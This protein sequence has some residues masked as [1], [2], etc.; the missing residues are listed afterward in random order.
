MLNSKL[1][2]VFFTSLLFLGILSNA[3]PVGYY[4]GT[5]GKNG[6]EL[7]T[8]LNEIISHHV[9]FGYTYTKYIINY[10]DADP[11]NP[12]N[13]ILFY[14]Q[15]SRDANDYGT[16]GDYINREHVWAKSHGNFTDKRPMYTDAHNLRPADASV[17]ED[18]GNKD[19]DN[20]QPGGNQNP[21][22]LYCYYTDSTWEPG[23]LT[24]GQVARILFY[25]A[26]RYE[27]N[28]GEMDL[29]LVRHNHT[30]PLPE[31]G[32]LDALLKWNKEY[33]PS[34]FERRRN[35][36][37][38]RAQ[39][40]RNPFVDHPEFADFI[41][42]NKT[43]DDIRFSN[44]SK[45]PEN[46]TPGDQISISLDITGSKTI[47]KVS[48]NWGKTYDSS[49]NQV[50]MQASGNN[51]TADIQPTDVI[52]GDMLYL[53]VKAETADSTY[54]WRASY[55]YPEKVD[56]ASITPIPDVQGTG[57]ASPIQNQEVT[58]A[59]RLTAN[60]DYSFYMQTSDG[61]RSGINVYNT[62]F[63]G[64]P[65]DSIIVRGTVDEY[66][67][68]TEITDVSYIHNYRSNKEV[69]PKVITTADFNEAHEGML[70]T[71]QN[72]S[73]QNGGQTIPEG[74]TSLTLADDSG[75]GTVFISST[76][77]LIGE[78]LLSGNVSVTGILGQY[79][80]TYQLMPRNINDIKIYTDNYEPRK[81]TSEINLYPNPVIDV[82]SINSQNS[83]AR[84]SFYNLTGQLVL[85]LKP[86]SNQVN[87][88]ALHPGIYLLR[89]NFS[90]GTTIQEK[91]LKANSK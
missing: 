38:Y 35:E 72:A 91:I 19:F 30:F 84:V 18:R 75:S 81:P 83:I 86:S 33:P 14:T 76:S 48:L 36:R 4:N 37:L 79:K 25:M 65:G 32:N 5:E 74:N 45:S 89:V 39:Q 26:T 28:D 68:L 82:L 17:N 23:P 61:S 87:V 55:L 59:G 42:N 47:N 24:K 9:D 49:D 3:Q 11:D 80:D 53:T 60:F 70:V 78:K 15:E 51:Y 8:T 69:T 20:I 62:I 2:I 31:H 6:D 22:A 44:F 43:P 66:N 56:I 67:N 54:S 85:N 57:D 63:R 16:G 12:N 50:A 13:V 10:S 71:V 40:N 73:F 34:D 27:G 46:P 88:S 41:W 77:R 21:E 58:I 64:N 52:A 29:K 7:K 1:K 90:N